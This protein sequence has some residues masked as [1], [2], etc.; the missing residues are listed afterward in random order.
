M[1]N[2]KFPLFG[3]LL[4]FIVGNPGWSVAGT[5]DDVGLCVDNEKFAF[6]VQFS[7][8]VTETQPD[9][10]IIFRIGA[11]G[12]PFALPTER[13]AV[14]FDSITG[15]LVT[16][17]LPEVQ[18]F[19]TPPFDRWLDGSIP[20]FAIE[21]VSTGV[22]GVWKISGSVPVGPD[23]FQPGDSIWG[24]ALRTTGTTVFSGAVEIDACESD[25][26][27]V[28]GADMALDPTA[29]TVV[30]DAG[31]TATFTTLVSNN[32]P[33]VAT[34]VF[35][36][37]TFT[38]P[39]IEETLPSECG[40]NAA[41]STVGCVFL[42]LPVGQ[43]EVLNFTMRFP[44]GG[45]QTLN[46][47]V[48]ADQDEPA[49]GNNTAS[50][51]I[52]VQ[53]SSGANLESVVSGLVGVNE[54]GHV[55]E[56]SEITLQALAANHGPNPAT[57][58][59]VEVTISAEFTLVDPDP[60]CI[61]VTDAVN[62]TLN[63]PLP[64]LPAPITPGFPT[65]TATQLRVM[66]PQSPHTNFPTDFTAAVSAT[67]ADPAPD[68]NIDSLPLSTR[69][70]ETDFEFSLVTSNSPATL[71][72]GSSTPPSARLSA[73]FRV[74]NL[75]PEDGS[76]HNVHVQ[77]SPADNVTDSSIAGEIRGR[78]EE[79][80]C[81][82][83]RVGPVLLFACELPRLVRL[84]PGSTARRINVSFHVDR[85]GDY[86]VKVTV[87]P[88][89]FDPDLS[90]NT[91]E[92]TLTVV[93]PVWGDPNPVSYPDGTVVV[94]ALEVT[95]A[96][97]TWEN[98]VRLSEHHRT[99]VRGFVQRSGIHDEPFVARLHGRR[100]GVT[101]AGSP[102]NA[103]NA[104]SAVVPRPQDAT[105]TRVFRNAN[106]VF[107]L[108]GDWTTGTV[109][110]ELEVVTG[111]VPLI[112]AEPMTGG[113]T[114]PAGDCTVTVEFVPAT[115]Q[116]VRYFFIRYREDNNASEPVSEPTPT[117]MLEQVA[118]V[119]TLFPF[120]MDIEYGHTVITEW[121][122]SRTRPSAGEAKSH[123]YR[124][125][126][127]EK[128]TCGVGCVVPRFYGVLDGVNP[129]SAIGTASTGGGQATHFLRNTSA[130]LYTG[131]LRNVVGQELAH[132]LGVHHTVDAD[133]PL[134]NEGERVGRCGSTAPE[135][136]PF[137]P[138]F[139]D[140][141]ISP[142]RIKPA[143]GPTSQVPDEQAWG[144]D[145]R[146]AYNDFADLN[147]ISPF[148]TWAVMSY[149]QGGNQ[150]SWS[151]IPTWESLFDAPAPKPV[152][153]TVDAETTLL[154]IGS[155]DAETGAALI[156]P[157]SQADGPPIDEGEASVPTT[158]RVSLIGFDGLEIVGVDIA[159]EE[160]GLHGVQDPDLPFEQVSPSFAAFLPK[161]D[162]PIAAV[163]VSD[164]AGEVGRR[165]ASPRPP[166]VEIIAPVSGE[167]LDTEEVTLAWNAG[168]P[169]GDPIVFDILYSADNGETWKALTVAYPNQS[170]TVP[171]SALAA[172]NAGRL[173]VVAS[174]GVHT[175][176]AESEVFAVADNPPFLEILQPADGTF[177]SG[178][179]LLPLEAVG[180]DPDVGA[181]DGS[182]IVWSS[183]INGDI[184]VGSRPELLASELSPGQHTLTVSTSLPGL[185]ASEQ[186]Q[187]IILDEHPGLSADDDGDGLTLLEEA[188]FVTDP[189]N[190]DSDGD[191]VIDGLD[192]SWIVRV[193]DA[194]DAEVFKGKG[195]RTEIKAH[196]VNFEKAIRKGDMDTAVKGL[197]NL[198][199]HM[200]GCSPSAAEADENDWIL[201]C[202]A[203]DALDRL[204]AILRRNLSSIRS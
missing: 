201:Q 175:A 169:D 70:R 92:H 190:P 37:A 156:A 80:S 100:N 20:D 81:S 6:S 131:E 139:F 23:T 121:D 124:M 78:I 160:L 155:I 187:V 198:T 27:P 145:T 115:E 58:V 194:F 180:F 196:L 36:Q 203:Q 163:V 94:R 30:V 133:L 19:G 9:N 71:S 98:S 35:V 112:C 166:E 86:E 8:Q 79:L 107:S 141:G 143:L 204:L 181:L 137:H 41:T 177:Y 168:D 21:V 46:M 118:R 50:V 186:V 2:S 3:L 57:G 119:K 87:E 1:P 165:E 142:F 174:D 162:V 91:V 197:E 45:D 11:D 192:T 146:F 101:L 178:D 110:L 123:L 69:D 54:L 13:I 148:E 76:Y 191:N 64:D 10:I 14:N 55:L 7:V 40:F 56:G 202:E 66:V 83:A 105:I 95:Q 4:A 195:H 51:L 104:G 24:V 103:T 22:T 158:H 144:F 39:V 34:N 43:I 68:N 172:T 82:E 128:Q 15:D 88:D 33:E 149:C 47:E 126:K 106:Y 72:V 184:A 189:T 29:D 31:D 113:G 183:D 38:G 48:T 53:G 188:E 111:S 129:T 159:I 176:M 12:T 63:C 136:F 89:E 147:V 16:A 120:P 32:G 44:D 161:P 153:S 17:Q 117:E 132:T 109:E 5:V 150:G 125:R 18:T 114:D 75:G 62:H 140:T 77:I 65:E 73:E 28:T 151:S 67:E 171:R 108:L 127:L 185:T 122:D 130:E 134:N 84:S 85:P 90:N 60:A 167:L 25:P 74:K 102:L 170:L 59:S 200:D 193:V 173:R 138:Y 26:P 99:V 182:Q 96:I 52:E 154:V 179:Q 116:P 42:N 97:Q 199:R 49:P 93:P 152:A 157:L 61:V 164:A 135:T